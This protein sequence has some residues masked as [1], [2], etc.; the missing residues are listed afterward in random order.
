MSAYPLPV[1]GSDDP[2]TNGVIFDA[3]DFL[4][5]HGVPRPDSAADWTRLQQALYGFL[6]AKDGGR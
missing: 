5:A 4:E 6:Y 1:T 2:F 3:A